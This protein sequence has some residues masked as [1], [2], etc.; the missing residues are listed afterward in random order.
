MKRLLATSLFIIIIHTVHAQNGSKN[1]ID[2][3]YIE[4]TG[5][6]EMEVIPN[7]IYLHITISE[8]DK[9]GKESVE[10]QERRMLEALRK[11]DSGIDKNISIISFSSTYIRYF[12][13]KSDIEKTKQYELLITDTL[14][15]APIFATLDELEISNVSIVKLDH[16]EMDTFK[17]QTK[18]KAIKAAQEKA[19]LYTNAIHQKI[20][21]ALFIQEINATVLQNEVLEANTVIRQKSSYSISKAQGISP[22]IQLKKIVIT[23]KILTRFALQ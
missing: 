3:N 23:A 6:A 2:Q 22:N 10:L 18:I 19:K 7:R 9:K 21:K 14:K 15:L 17:Q 1:F 11:I 16:S 8:K 13:K 4:V 5:T 12:F 20:G